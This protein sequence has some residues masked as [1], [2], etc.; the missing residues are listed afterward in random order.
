LRL[1][2]HRCQVHYYYNY[3]YDYYYY[4]YYCYYNYYNYNCSY[5]ESDFDNKS[6]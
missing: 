4:Y 1:H 5:P 2:D 3:Y 6:T